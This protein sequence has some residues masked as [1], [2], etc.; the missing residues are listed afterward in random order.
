MSKWE[1]QGRRLYEELALLLRRRCPNLESFKRKCQPWFINER[2]LAG[3]VRDN[4]PTNQFLITHRHL[5]IV[6]IDRLTLQEEEVATRVM[7]PEYSTE[8]SAEEI[9]VVEKFN[10]C[11]IQHHGVYDPLAS[12][13]RLKHLD[14]GYGNRYPWEYKS[15]DVYEGKD[16]EE[17]L[18]YDPPTF[19]TLELTLESGLSKLGALKNLEMFGFE[20]INH[21]IGKT[22]LEW[23]AKSWPNLNLMYGLDHE[24]LYNIERDKDNAALREYFETLRPDV[25]C[26]NDTV[27][28]VTLNNSTKRAHGQASQNQSRPGFIQENGRTRYN[29]LYR[30]NT[31]FDNTGGT[32]LSPWVRPL[33]TRQIK[34]TASPSPFGHMSD[35]ILDQ[36]VPELTQEHFGQTEVLRPAFLTPTPPY[37]A[38]KGPTHYYLAQMSEED[39]QTQIDFELCHDLSAIHT[40]VPGPLIG[41]LSISTSDIYRPSG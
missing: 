21:K 29:L 10:R 34:G 1:A 27:S 28:S 6:G 36:Q 16:G 41:D 31:T 11:R 35:I 38:I 4:D 15:G 2:Y 5:Q 13:T 33:T 32:C 3:G 9:G 40:V 7:A 39:C 24:R 12:L 30:R 22:E 8:L 26:N 18:Y 14:L 20:C 19:E 25:Q 23:M 37:T 17:Y